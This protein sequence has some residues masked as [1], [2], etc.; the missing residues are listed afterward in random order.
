MYKGGLA[1]LDDRLTG[2]SARLVLVVF[3]HALRVLLGI[4]SCQLLG[5]NDTISYRHIAPFATDYV[6]W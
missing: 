3:E 5:K 6:A 4:L 2:P 1:A